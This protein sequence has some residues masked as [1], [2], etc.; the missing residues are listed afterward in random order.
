MQDSLEFQVHVDGFIKLFLADAKAKQLKSNLL[1][2]RF[3]EDIEIAV[4]WVCAYLFVLN[5]RIFPF[6][7]VY[8]R[9]LIL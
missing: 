4:D 3:I 7:I 8:F 5:V 2:D 9:M 6:W 1:T